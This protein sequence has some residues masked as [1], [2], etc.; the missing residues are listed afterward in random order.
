MSDNQEYGY[1]IIES[2]TF[3]D[4]ENRRQD[5]FL[6]SQMLE[7]CG[8]PCIYHFIRTKIELRRVIELF[9]DSN[10]RYLHFSSHGTERTVD[11]SLE[12]LRFHE[13]AK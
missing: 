11:L 7:L 2:L 9:R 1:F 13:F 5:G 6:L 3:E 8:I 12:S 10:Y 4:E